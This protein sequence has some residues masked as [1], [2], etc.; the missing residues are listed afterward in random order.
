MGKKNRNNR[1]KPKHKLRSLTT[2]NP[3]SQLGGVSQGSS[4]TYIAP[5]GA[6]IT[7]SSLPPSGLED[8]DFS[9]WESF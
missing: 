7:V 8:F 6:T 4:V 3:T 9:N 2:K 5:N 1:L